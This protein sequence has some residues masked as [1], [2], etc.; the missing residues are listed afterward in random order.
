M[1]D[2]G[3]GSGVTE[4]SL[5]SKL[6][7]SSDLSGIHQLYFSYLQPFSPVL[8]KQSNKSPKIDTTTLRSLA[9][10]FLSFINKSLSLL[11]KRLNET[12]KIDSSYASELFDTYKLC[13][14]CLDSISSQLACKPHSLQIQRLWLIRCYVNWGRYEEAQLEGVSVL[15]FIEN[16]S[17]KRNGNLSGRIVPELRKEND[18]KDIAMLILDVVVWLVKCVANAQSKEEEDYYR[19]LSMVNETQPWLRVIGTDGYD[20]L[21]RMLVS[22][23]SKCALFLVGE[24]ANF[25][26]N[27]T[28]KFFVETFSEYRRSSLNDQTEKF[29]HNICSSLFSQ[30]DNEVLASEKILTLVLDTMANE[31]MV[32]K[33]KANVNFLELAVYVAIKCRNATVDFCGAVASH[34]KKLANYFSQSPVLVTVILQAR[35][36]TID[37]IMRLYAITFSVGD[38]NYYS[39]GGNSKI[40][41]AENGISVPK[42]LLD[43]E[44]QLQSLRTSITVHTETYMPFYF[45][46]LKFLCEPLSELIQSERKDIL[47]GFDEMSFPIKLPN[48]DDVFQQ[49][50]LVFDAYRKSEKEKYVYEDNSRAVFAVATAAFTLSFTTNQNLEESTSFLKELISIKWVQV[51]GLKYLYAC[52]HNVGLVL[53]RANRLKEATES[54]NLSC[55]AAW[56]CVMHFC[57]KFVSNKDE[58]SSELSEDAITAFVTETCAKS[59]FLLDILHQCGTGSEEISMI[60]TDFLESWSAAQNWFDKIPVPVA[61]VEQWVKIICEETEDPEDECRVQTIYSLMSSSS[62]MPKETLGFL[63]EQELEAYREMKSLNPELCK[64]MQTTI[65]NI[66][67]ED[68][69]CTKDSIF[70]KSRILI[71]KARESRAC[72]VQGL[73]ECIE[74]LSEA[75]SNMSDMYEKNKEACG[76][77]CNLLAVAY[78]LRALCTQEAEPN[79]KLLVQDIGCALKLWLSQDHSQAV[80][81]VDMVSHNTLIL[82]Y[83]V[84]DLLSLKGCMDVHSDIYELMIRFFTCKNVSLKECLAMLWQSKSLSHALCTSHVNDAFILTFSKHCKL[85]QSLEFWKSCMEKSKSLEIGFQQC[86]SVISTLSFPSSC[87]HDRATECAHLTIDDIKKTAFDLS[88]SV[89]PSSKSLFL[90]SNLYYDLSERLISKGSMIEALSYAKEAHRLRTKLFQKNFIYSIEQHNDII[91]E[92]GEI[93]QK[94]GYG[95]KSFHMQPSIATTSW[96]ND[97]GSSEFDFILTP[98]NILRCY[99]ES[100][101]QVGTIQEIVGNGSEAEALLLWGKNISSFQGLPIISVSFSTILGKLYRKQQRWHLAEKELESANHTLVDS[102]SLY[103]CLKC[104]LILEVTIDQQLG[105]LFR[106]RFNSTIDNKLEGL[107]KAETFYRSATEKLKLSEWKNCVSDPKETISKNTMFC[108][109]VLVGGNDVIISSDCGNHEEQ[110]AI[111]PKV[112]RKGKKTAKSK[113]QEQR[114]TSRITRSSKQKSVNVQNELKGTQ[115]SKVGHIVSCGCEVTCVFDDANCWHCV[116]FGVMKSSSLTS[117]IHMKWECTRRRLLV[118]L[119]IGI[120]KCS[121]ARGETQR[122]NEA[123]VESL[124]VLVSRSTFHP[125][126]FKASFS[127]L[128]ELIKNN[129]IA[130]VFAIE[131]AAL[132]YNMCWFSLRSSSDNVTRNH[133]CDMSFIPI[134][135]VV[136]GLK[137]SFIVCREVPELF[138]KVSQLLAVLYTLSPSTK[139]FS[140]LTLSSNSLSENQWASYFHQA[141]LGTHVNYQLFSRLG[142]QK[143]QNTMDVDSIFPSSSTSLRLHRLAPESVLDLEDFILKFFQGLPGATIICISILGDDACWLRTF[144][145]YEPSNHSWIMFSRLNSDCAPIVIVL[146]IASILLGSP[147]DEDSSSDILFEKKSSDKLWHCPWGHTVVDEVAP[148]FRTIL[149]ESYLSSSGYTTLEDTK[150]N[151]LIWWNRRR[152]LDQ[153]LGEFLRDMEDLWFGPWK[154][155]LLG[156]L[157]D[158]RHIDFLQ[159]K[160]RKDLK[161]KCKFDVHENIIKAVI[162]GGG[163]RKECLSELIKKKGCYIG[164][165]ACIDDGGL[166]SLVS[167]L[168][169]NTMHEIGEEDYADREPVI[170][171]PDFDIQMLPWESLP[172]LR[173][174]EVYRMPSVA[175]ISC[176]Y[177]RCCHFQ[178]KVGEDSSLFPMIDPLDAYY[179]LNPGGDLYRTEA[180]FGNWF[181]DQNFEGTAGTSPSVDE[182]S[183]A[184]KSHDLF[185]YLGHG[186]GVQYIPGGEIQKLERCAA[187]LLM[188]CSS[189]SLSLNGSYTPKGAPLYY[190][191]AGSPES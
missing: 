105:D 107:S 117:A 11:P 46:A 92:N 118:K 13:F 149:E 115:K 153:R 176:T 97:K 139:A 155:L 179:L 64:V 84:C 114:V 95:L 27:L 181:K 157:S 124:S 48:I 127:F 121:W 126:K 129:V 56:K 82:L 40:P 154:H 140:P 116:P 49:F 186:S 29:A 189:G 17:G 106:S 110:E 63:L 19:V 74:F 141:S 144:L 159:K 167:D 172:V 61:L 50:R 75:T 32:G 28:C 146:P 38:L 54:F 35:L 78:C 47:C 69:Y 52:L 104:R 4:S 1:A 156:G 55:Q 15:G 111:Q 77:V 73:N 168:L 67:L 3:T 21:H 123:F 98:W 94:C 90:S 68:I 10:K 161:S 188:G 175:S 34:F 183:V 16:L 128:G 174:Q 33:E 147:N 45:N 23:M 5:L 150:Q 134:P 178:E 190:L 170:L 8:K 108:D 164:G 103:S 99:L 158:H 169:L 57:R 30:L 87:N 135:I 96:S 37:L 148:L 85:S 31:C 81:Q 131:Y 143:D 83:N 171:V 6:E 113:P 9:K 66:L 51:S 182:L 130:D 102:F 7:S 53:Y 180:E 163:H 62:K 2:S 43:V 26:V 70:Q 112:T 187:T 109:R 86:F 184:L 58:S 76:P 24:L 72:G 152:K 71:A 162:R 119:L 65:S 173:N 20:K 59:A 185:I 22:Y 132:L 44:N 101:L 151:R 136:S 120:G 41:K 191:F 160:L 133:S 142:K 93:I 79:S 12:P 145:P 122:A 39:R 60:L 42:L 137:L 91:G 18:D 138:R 166:S 88:N 36:S 80:E 25:D 100:I 89:P 177:D 14:N 125:S 165:R